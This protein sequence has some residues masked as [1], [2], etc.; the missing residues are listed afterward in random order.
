[1][2][3]YERTVKR[4]KENK[5][6]RL[7]GDIIALPWNLPRLSRI[8]PGVEPETITIISSGPKALILT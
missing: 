1:M 2:S 3:L 8:L 7:R 6:K 4:I 5:E